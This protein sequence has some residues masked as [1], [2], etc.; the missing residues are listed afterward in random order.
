MEKVKVGA[1]KPGDSFTTPL[2]DRRGIVIGFDGIGPDG[3]V[4]VRFADEDK[5]LHPDVMVQID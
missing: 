4:E 5:W 3:A 2:T 1:L